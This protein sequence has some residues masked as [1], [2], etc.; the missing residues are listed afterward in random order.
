MTARPTVT[1]P[2]LLRVQDAAKILDVEATADIMDR[3]V[4]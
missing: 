4:K 2:Q 3:R 1:P